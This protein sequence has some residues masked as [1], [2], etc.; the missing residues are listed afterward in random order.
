MSDT[1]TPNGAPGTTDQWPRWEGPQQNQPRGYLKAKDDPS[2]DRDAVGENL[3][4]PR[5][6]DLGDAM[7]TRDDGGR[8]RA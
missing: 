5:K 7:K 8:D 4:D 1:P 3:E 6:T 2:R